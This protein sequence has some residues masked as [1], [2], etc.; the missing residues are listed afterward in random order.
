MY[1]YLLKH[2]FLDRN[3]INAFV[4]AGLLY[5]NYLTENGMDNTFKEFLLYSE[6]ANDYGNGQ[7]ITIPSSLLQQ[8]NISPDSDIQIICLDGVLIIVTDSK[9]SLSGLAAVLGGYLQPLILQRLSLL[10]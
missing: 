8:A 6:E 10:T 5:E 2:R 7:E 1:A 3:I 4:R 9:L